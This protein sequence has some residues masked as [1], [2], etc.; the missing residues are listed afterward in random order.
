MKKIFIRINNFIK[1]PLQPLV[2]ANNPERGQVII[3]VAMAMIGLVAFVGLAI[4][5]GLVFVGQ[6][7]LRRAVDAAALAAASNFRQGYDID[8]L[9]DS[10]YELLV[11][12]GV[13][14]PLADPTLV[15]QVDT[16]LS[17]PED[18]ELCVGEEEG[19]RKLVRV[20][21]TGT[22]D[23]AFLSVIGIN[24]VS[25]SASA[26]GEAASMDLVLVIDT[27]DSMARDTGGAGQADND[28]SVCNLDNS[29]YPFHDVKDAADYFVSQLV[30]PYDRVAVIAFDREARIYDFVDLEFEAEAAD[31]DDLGGFSN[32]LTA[33]GNAIGGM[34]VYDPRK[35]P[36]PWT[37]DCDDMPAGWPGPCRRY[38]ST[39]YQGMD[40]PH[41]FATGNPTDCTTTNIG[42][43]VYDTGNLLA[44]D[45]RRE[46]HWVVVLLTDGAAN[47]SLNG[48]YCPDVWWGDPFCRSNLEANW[49]RY[50]FDNSYTWCLKPKIDGGPGGEL[51]DSTDRK[52]NSDDFARDMFD[53]VGINQDAT[54][55]TIGLGDQV[56]TSLPIVDG[57][58]AG[59]RLLAYAASDA[60][61]AGLYIQSAS[62]GDLQAA[63]DQI[64]DRIATR[65]SK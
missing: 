63:F 62:S 46:A 51:D 27:S 55:F 64:L 60:V 7:R 22:V 2:S 50:C 32:D 54:I 18:P 49:K 36:S 58:G 44:S 33:I 57:Q 4:D 29:C 48:S 1:N 35:P 28:P 37:G 42:E 16:C 40:C 11:L 43:G 45:G 34:K 41:F 15:S 14:D 3:I 5:T 19:G 59:E 17:L 38:I 12:N 10:A 31:V 65:L 6:G 23:L 30:F 8:E 56:V 52:Y 24:D 26:T 25:I 47:S 21:A 13:I 9:R 61:G 53:Y 39:I 20:D